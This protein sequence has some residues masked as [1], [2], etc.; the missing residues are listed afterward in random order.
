MDTSWICQEEESLA[1]RC[2]CYTQLVKLLSCL[3]F[4]TFFFQE[5]N[6]RAT[7]WISSLEL[8]LG[9]GAEKRREASCA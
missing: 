9:R 3:G 5:N 8:K 6:E 2:C 4:A 7:K 1:V